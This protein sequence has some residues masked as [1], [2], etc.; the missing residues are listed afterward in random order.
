MTNKEFEKQLFKWVEKNVPI[1]FTT[2]D[3]LN[4]LTQNGKLKIVTCNNCQH[5]FTTT[6]KD[7]RRIKCTKCGSNKSLSINAWQTTDESEES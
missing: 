3:V 1:P 5:E 4:M 2:K 7:D 6:R